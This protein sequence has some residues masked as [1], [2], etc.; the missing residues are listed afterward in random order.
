MRQ[1]RRARVVIP[2]AVLALLAA[3]CGQTVFQSL[4]ATAAAAPAFLDTL[5]NENVINAAEADRA[6]VDLDRMV[7]CV[8]VLEAD[9]DPLAKND[10]IGKLN[11]W[12]KAGKCWKSIESG[13]NFEVNPRLQ[14]IANLIKAAF[15]V[16]IVFYST[17]GEIVGADGPAV[18]VGDEKQL[19]KDL[20]ARIQA[21]K[22][23]M[24]H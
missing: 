3:A 22:D 9:L 17:P 8:N 4:R 15:S 19:E 20:R 10:R 1:V 18:P 14:K 16:G 2:V 21:I 13:G 12:V 11:A 23:A 7:V 6:Q 24:K 5:V